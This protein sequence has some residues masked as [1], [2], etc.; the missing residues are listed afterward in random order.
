MTRRGFR[1]VTEWAVCCG[2]STLRRKAGGNP[3][4]TYTAQFSSD[5]DT[6]DDFSGAE[7]VS[8]ID[9]TWERVVI[10]DVPPPGAT[11]RYGRVK[12]VL[13]P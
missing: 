13:N 4:I 9:T 2:S 12:V 11:A 1:Q 5:L 7:S 6:W 10:D 8:S 3:G